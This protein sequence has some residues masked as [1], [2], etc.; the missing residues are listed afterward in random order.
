MSNALAHFPKWNSMQGREVSHAL[1][2]Q[3]G[4]TVRRRRKVIEAEDDFLWIKDALATHRIKIDDRH[5]RG[6]I[7]AQ[8]VIDTADHQI[9][10]AGIP[11]RFGGKDLLADGF[12]RHYDSS[13][14]RIPQLQATTS[15]SHNQ[16]PPRR[17]SVA[18]TTKNQTHHG[19]TE[20]R[21]KTGENQLHRGGAEKNLIS[22]TICNTKQ[23][24]RIVAA[25]EEFD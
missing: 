8:S 18:A 10:G 17:H 20:T 6:T 12:A 22:M 2:Q 1:V 15:Q 5:G 13:R 21:R 16:N 11:P 9:A 25:R 23:S 3:A 14:L 4:C 24:K 19:G 7:G